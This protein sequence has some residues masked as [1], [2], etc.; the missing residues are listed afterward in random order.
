MNRYVHSK[1][2]TVVI[3]IIITLLLISG[4]LYLFSQN[5]TR[6]TETVTVAVPP[7]E[8]NA[9]IYVAEN[10][11]FFSKNGLAVTIKNYD[12]GVTAIEA[13]VNGEADIS[14]AAEFPFVKSVFD[15]K[16]LSII[17]I[18]DEFQ[19]DYVV[20][21]RSRGIENISDL[22]GKTVGL[23]KGT[24][25]EF[26]FG[27]FLELNGIN[28]N[29]LSIIDIK[30]GQFLASLTNGEIDAI[31]AWQPYINQIHSQIK[32]TITW[33]VQNGQAVYGILICRNQW[34]NQHAET[35]EY[36]LKALKEAEQFI[37]Y[38]PSEAKAIVQ[39]KLNYADTYMEEVWSQHSF[40]LSLDQELIVAM[41]DEA[42]W[43]INNNLA[44][45]TTTLP[46]FVN[47]IYLDGLTRIKPES[48]GIIL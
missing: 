19:N 23:A 25:V 18:N 48:I 36:F 28:Q 12:S 11:G 22:K 7:L 8:Q 26:Y 27:R 5:K 30:P 9:L 32:E 6:G 45:G 37:A 21:L 1:A 10:Q 31:A 33:P 43:L 2:T 16:N 41:K 4:T 17:S 24:I 47:C 3:V 46:N 38:H 20:A 15:N 34:L 29:D 35:S 40:Q 39:R 14:E 13:L 42:Q 44:N